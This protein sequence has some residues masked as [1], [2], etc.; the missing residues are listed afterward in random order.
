MKS[1]PVKMPSHQVPQIRGKVRHP[2]HAACEDDLRM[3][4]DTDAL[5]FLEFEAPGVKGILT[6]NLFEYLVAGPPIIAVGINSQSETGLIIERNGRGNAFGVDVGPLAVAIQH[7]L[8]SGVNY[9]RKDR[10]SATP[11]ILC[12]SRAEQAARLISILS[13]SPK[14]D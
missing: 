7:H 6:G 9:Q 10:D 4:R 11:D 13:K 3:Q 8:K 2:C 14:K 1:S 5:I 12:F